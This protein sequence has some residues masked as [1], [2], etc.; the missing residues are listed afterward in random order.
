MGILHALQHAEIQPASAAVVK[1]GLQPRAKIDG[2]H[3]SMNVHQV[4]EVTFKNK[5]C[6][7]DS[8][9]LES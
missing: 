2:W 3:V 9:C 7:R 6:A 5:S 8:F 1:E 4:E